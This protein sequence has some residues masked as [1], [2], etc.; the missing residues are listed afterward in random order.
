M[1]NER[2]TLLDDVFRR[3][4]RKIEG[5]I[6]CEG[7]SV[8]EVT[9]AGKMLRFAVTQTV[10]RDRLKGLRLRVGVGVA[11]DVAQ[12]NRGV[13]LAEAAD[14]PSFMPCADRVLK[15]TTKTLLCCPMRLAGEVVGVIELVNKRDEEVFTERELEEVQRLV[16]AEAA[17]WTA[18]PHDEHGTLFD[19]LARKIGE[20]VDVEGIS[21]LTM[22]SSRKHLAFRFSI[23]AVETTLEGS[24]I[25]VGQGIAGSVAKSAKAAL[26]ENVQEDPRFFA[27][28]DLVTMFSTRSVLAVPVIVDGTV[29]SVLELVRSAA[30]QPFT[31]A[32]Q[33]ILEEITEE[34]V[35]ELKQK[36]E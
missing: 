18:E 15:F 28:V 29:H 1:A 31:P 16:D 14:D 23:T 12:K 33:H 24:R 19:G 3:T 32:D 17:R 5:R 11:G 36:V 8:L 21:L 35:S 22:E 4:V 13:I 20:I 10:G 25:K 34:L 26:V 30:S 6:A 2:Q 27:G 9:E 7:I